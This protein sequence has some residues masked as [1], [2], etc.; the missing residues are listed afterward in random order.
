MNQSVYSHV[1]VN[2]LLGEVNSRVKEINHVLNFQLGFINYEE[3]LGLFVITLL[4]L[5]VLALYA[6]RGSVA[7]TAVVISV[8]GLVATVVGLLPS[9]QTLLGNQAVLPGIFVF[10]LLMAGIYFWRQNIGG[11]K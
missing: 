6:T 11:G 4:A 8:L 9:E 5:S 1:E 7:I 10:S 2:H 3:P